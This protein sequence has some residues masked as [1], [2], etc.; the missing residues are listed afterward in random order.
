VTARC[1]GWAKL[2]AGQV[3]LQVHVYSVLLQ[4]PHGCGMRG[5]QRLRTRSVFWRDQMGCWAGADPG[6]CHVCYY[7]PSLVKQPLQVSWETRV[8]SEF[9]V[10]VGLVRCTI[11]QYIDCT[12]RVGQVQVHALFVRHTPLV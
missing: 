5:R 8:C 6:A 4:G 2:G 1:L 12:V 11:A 10:F 9:C 3:Q 7:A